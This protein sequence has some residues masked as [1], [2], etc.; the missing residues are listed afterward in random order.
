MFI[1]E[2]IE[3]EEHMETVSNQMLDYLFDP[4][5]TALKNKNV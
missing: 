2:S 1:M 5:K 3:I 4:V